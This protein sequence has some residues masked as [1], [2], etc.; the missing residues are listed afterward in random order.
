MSRPTR[1]SRRAL[2]ALAAAIMALGLLLAACSGSGD[3]A[4][5]S[6]GSDGGDSAGD[7]DSGGSAGGEPAGG[8]DAPADDG[9]Q[10]A[11]G[12]WVAVGAQGTIRTSEDGS[13]WTQRAS[14]T[15]EALQDV[16]YDPQAGWIA[17][18][19]EGTVLT[20]EDGKV[21]TVRESGTQDLLYRVERRD[22]QWVAHPLT[23][24]AIA[25]TSADGVSWQEI[26]QP[27]YAGGSGAARLSDLATDGQ[28]TWVGLGEGGSFA[29]LAVISGDG[30]T[31]AP[32]PGSPGFLTG[33]TYGDGRWVAVGARAGTTFTTVSTDG[34][35]WTNTDL[36][37][38]EGLWNPFELS[39]VAYD[40]TGRWVLV[41]E[42]GA[43]YS[44]PD[45]TAWTRHTVEREAFLRGIDFA[46]EA[47]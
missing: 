24:R 10:G 16:M 12:I 18:G 7:G 39:D 33:I 31:F 8:D 41:A 37:R 29:G 15:E 43:I 40:G 23:G 26:S 13:T 22:G 6:A 17:V 46:P 28:G 47:G 3:R 30:L 1:T 20:S 38:G 21:W 19:L 2:P 42:D 25:Y 32:V 34:T 5:S 44:S 45:A 9:A 27:S 36:P 4:G 11:A 14:G 35:A